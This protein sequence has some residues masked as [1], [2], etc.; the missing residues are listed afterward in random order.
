MN[1]V[2][3]L[4]AVPAETNRHQ[5]IKPLPNEMAQSLLPGGMEGYTLNNELKSKISRRERGFYC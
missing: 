3:L 4:D 5:F 2:L 1:T